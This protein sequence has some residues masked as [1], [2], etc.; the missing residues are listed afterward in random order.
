MKPRVLLS[1]ACRDWAFHNIAEQLVLRLCSHFDFTVETLKEHRPADWDVAV[2]FYW[3]E[4]SWAA[5]NV[6]RARRRIVCVYDHASWKSEPRAI[7]ILNRANVVVAANQRLASELVAAGVTRPVQVCPDGV[8]LERF[9]LLPLP[10]EFTA[11]WCGNAGVRERDPDFKG[12]DLIREACAIAS[13]PL[14]V[15]EYKERIPHVEMAER[16][17]RR[18]TTYVCASI[19]EGTP[20]PVLEALACGRPVISTRVGLVPELLDEIAPVVVV[21][22]DPKQIASALAWT[23]ATLASARLRARPA[24]EEHDW[25][26]AAQ[27]WR[28]TLATIDD[29]LYDVPPELP[30]QAPKVDKLDL[31]DRVT[32]FLISSGEPSTEE[33]RRR[34]EQQSCTFTLQEIRDVVPMDRALQQMIDRCETALY[35]Q[36]D[37]DMLLEP[38]AIRRLAAEID[39]CPP[40]TAMYV[41]SLWGDAEDRPIQGVKIYRHELLS[42]FPYRPSMSCEVPQIEAMQATGLTIAAQPFPEHRVECFGLHFSLQTEE[43][44]FRRQ[45]RLAHKF[46]A[47]AYMQWWSGQPRALME[48]WQADP[49]P[50]NAAAF[51]GAVAGLVGELPPET[52]ANA[53][54]IN[55]DYE[56]V[57]GH[58]FRGGDTEEHHGPTELTLYATDR[59][60]AACVGCW[61][62]TNNPPDKDLSPETVKDILDR[63]PTIRSTCI[64]GFGEPLMHQRLGEVVAM[65]RE[66]GI[67]TGIITN[68]VLLKKRAAEVI[69]WR[70]T[71]VTVSL[72]ATD[73]AEHEHNQGVRGAW[74]LVL[75]GVRAALDGGLDVGLSFICRRQNA[76][77]IPRMLDVALEVGANFVHLVN[78]LPHEGHDAE[79][80]RSV[81]TRECWEWSHV[82]AA[83]QHPGARLVRHWPTPIT[84]DKNPPRRCTSP[85]RLLGV[86]VHGHVTTCRRLATPPSFGKLHYAQEGMW[87]DPELVEL[88]RAMRWDLPLPAPCR[89]CFGCWS[90]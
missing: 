24:A 30:A 70:P 67:H 2:F 68:G 61:R 42:R 4:A 34:L 88:R 8:D 18:I 3:D 25:A 23:K 56:R 86:D 81:L 82:E 78:L 33:C 87:R 89:S 9:P 39:A 13:V 31:R 85:F 32:V 5:S 35:V 7:A 44:A 46:R 60:N 27:A 22:R 6:V 83:K 43:M 54:V 84:L 73:A 50:V 74:Q 10:E 40:T 17:Y 11:G 64:A 63:F 65:L 37:A 12:I 49:T 58:L 48:R 59:C 41:G 55:H 57:T 62:A 14:V 71:V 52:E 26:R 45:Q 36:V 72:N 38:W 80:E 51:L 53:R 1:I 90:G 15:Q 19:S 20:N 21:D 66:R 77:Q 47:R 79:F 16:F 75:D 28:H 76:A 69:A 29:S